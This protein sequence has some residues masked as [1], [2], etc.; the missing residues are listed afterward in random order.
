MAQNVLENSCPATSDLF[1]D[2]TKRCIH[3]SRSVNELDK[4]NISICTHIRSLEDE[5]KDFRQERDEMRETIIDLRCRSM[6]NNLI[7]TGL[8]ESQ[9][10]NTEATLRELLRCELDI[11]YHIEF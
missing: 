11:E 4:D 9:H 10:E 1:D 2:V 5:L 6:K 3:N 7:F 8:G